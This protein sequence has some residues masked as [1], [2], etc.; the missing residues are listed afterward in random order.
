M[1]LV[2]EV[3]FLSGVSFAAIDQDS[4]IPDW[5]PQ[6]DRI[7]SALVATW[8]LRGEDDREHQALA[9]LEQQAVPRLLASEAYQRTGAAVFVPPNDPR[10]ERKKH[11]KGVLPALRSRRWR[12]FPTARPHNPVVRLYWSAEPKRDELAALQNLARDTA[13]VGHSASLTRCRFLLEGNEAISTDSGLPERCVYRGRLAELQATHAIFVRS[14]GKQG[15]PLLGARV[16]A[17]PVTERKRT[18]LFGKHWLILEH[19]SGTMPDIRACALV[20]KGIRD[21]LLSGYQ[22][23]SLGKAIPEVVSG[24]TSAGTP[25]REPHLAILPLCFA[26]YPHADGHVM[27]FALVPPRD[28]PILDSEE[29][30]RPLR[31]LAPI[32][33]S[34]GRRVLTVSPRRGASSDT[35]FAIDLSPTFEPPPGRQ[36]LDPEIYLRE[37][38]RY[39]TMTPIVLDRHLK[40]NGAA[41]QREIETLIV[42]ACRNIGL[43]EP[44]GVFPDKHSTLEGAVSAYPSD[45]SPAWMRW[46]VPSSLASRQ[47]SHAVIDFSQ[48]VSGPLILG[49]GRFLGL[50]LCRPLDPRGR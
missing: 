12:R 40:E 27:G 1:T 4:D 33:E 47:L 7:F 16:A 32:D 18:N 31:A 50:G 8:A 15:R 37:A 36:S 14:G 45:K 41:R 43:P 19:I 6:P 49:A 42:Q 22:R 44:S 23:I 48:P 10:S 35:G 28:S 20:A 3:E 29:F 30:R 9:W 26:G 13:Y 24:H 11:A 2:L 5:P 34:R 39:A 38:K 46:R 21:T 17:E 25:T